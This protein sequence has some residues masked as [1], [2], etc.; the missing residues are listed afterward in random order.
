MKTNYSTKYNEPL[1]EF[2]QKVVQCPN[3]IVY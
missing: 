1:G 3:R 2:K